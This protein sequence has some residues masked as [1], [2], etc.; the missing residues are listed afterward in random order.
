MTE[1]LR[2]IL[3]SLNV[4]DVFL[5]EELCMVSYRANYVI[6]TDFYSYTNSYNLDEHKLFRRL[7]T[8][9]LFDENE[10]LVFAIT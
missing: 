5:Y 10:S 6:Y 2:C 3:T 8:G 4:S 7:I 1:S 9:V